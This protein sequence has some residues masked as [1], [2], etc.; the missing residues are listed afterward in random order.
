MGNSSGF[1][2]CGSHHQGLSCFPGVKLI[3]F[4]KRNKIKV[5]FSSGNIGFHK[6]F[7]SG[8]V[9]GKDNISYHIL[10]W[11]HDSHLKYFHFIFLV[12]MELVL[13]YGILITLS[14]LV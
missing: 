8:H 6:D 3:V 12:V 13:Y 5:D 1:S 11:G 10:I 9:F 7:L 4:V 2:K 14:V